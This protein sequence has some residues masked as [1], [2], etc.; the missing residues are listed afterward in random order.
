MRGKTAMK[1]VNLTID[2][3]P[4]QVDENMTVLEAALQVGIDIPTLCFLKGVCEVGDCRICVVE[5]DGFDNLK[6][7]CV[8]P[9]SEG[10]VVKTHTKK[11]R[12]SRK[13][14]ME[15]I[16]ATHSKECLTCCRSTNCELQT[17]AEE[18]GITELYYSDESPEEVTYDDKSNSI[19][20]DQSKCILCARCAHVCS[21]T[22]GTGI[23]GFVGRGVKTRVTTAFDKSLADTPCLFCGQC[24][25]SCPVGAISEKVDIDKVWDV[26]EDPDIHVVVQTAPAVRSAL[27]E[28][29]G[30]PFGT[31]VQ[32][33]MVA[34]LK[35]LGFNKVYDTS[36][37]AD[38]T[39]MEEGH[40]LLDRLNNDGV[41]PMITSCSPGWVRYCEHYYPEFIP[42]LSSCKSPHQMVGAV[43][44]SYYAE[45]NNID[46]AKIFVVSVMPC[47]SKKDEAARPELSVNGLQDVDCVITTRELA[48]MIRIGRIDFDMLEDAEFDRDLLGEYTGAGISFGATGGVMEAS[49]RTV[50]DI[51]ESKELRDIDYTQ[52]RGMSDIKEATLVLG[53]RIF[54][55]AV[56]HGTA[57]AGRLLDLIK[58][59]VTT[60]DFIE[61]MGC[62]GGC[63]AG[64]GQP[65]VTAK[66]K[67]KLDIREAR[68]NVLR[69]VDNSKD[70]R[71][72]HQNPQVQKLYTDYLGK[73]NSQKAHELLHT[74]YTAKEKFPLE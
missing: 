34:A 26:L 24:V 52:V 46:P 16:L 41:L 21:K 28:E 69:E 15:L 6:S 8:F 62:S 74:H 2:D 51:M 63:V 72:S 19:I 7:A 58:S 45:K 13:S 27:G 25:V 59:G 68:A 56:V 42:N 61:V 10:M 39:I 55:V 67:M 33:K 9:V 40:E 66:E 70:Y 4:V 22:Q 64:G 30:L 20:R 29:F 53:G 49:L 12:L 36:F 71:K 48:K 3:L 35:R 73:P 14:T 54:R 31:N 37:G 43:L 18:L 65:H 60:Y 57:A 32:G 47:T 23:L 38:L 44:K 50:A 11:V 1:T 17:L 5:V